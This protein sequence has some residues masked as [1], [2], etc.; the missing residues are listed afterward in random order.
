ML[1][2]LTAPLRAA[3][4]FLALLPTASLAH[5][6]RAGVTDAPAA[7]VAFWNIPDEVILGIAAANRAGGGIDG[8]FTSPTLEA[9]DVYVLFTDPARSL[10]ETPYADVLGLDGEASK[11]VMRL[12]R[13]GLPPV[14][15]FDPALLDE[16]YDAACLGRLIHRTITHSVRSGRMSM[17]QLAACDSSVRAAIEG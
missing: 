10:G 12:A 14:L 2:R 11:R 9:Y 4:L 3:A 17:P 16:G 7:K 1:S 5:T 8:G 6:D 13:P 15:I